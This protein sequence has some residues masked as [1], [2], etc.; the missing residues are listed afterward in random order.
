VSTKEAGEIEFKV[1]L[2]IKLEFWEERER[3]RSGFDEIDEP[4]R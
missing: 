3:E 4:N 2:R 1:N